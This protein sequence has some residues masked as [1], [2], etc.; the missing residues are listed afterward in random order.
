MVKGMRVIGWTFLLFVAL[1]LS[2][3]LWEEY[4]TEYV[5]LSFLEPIDKWIDSLEV[6]QYFSE[7]K[8]YLKDIKAE[9]ITQP[10]EKQIILSEDGIE[11]EQ[12]KMGM[13]KSEIENAFGDPKRV[14][15]NEYNLVWHTY[16]E[17]YLNFFMVSYNDE[18][19]VNALFTNQPSFQSFLGLEMESTRDEVLNTLGDPIK[20]LRKG[21]IIYLLPDTGEYDLFLIN[22]NY[23]TFFYDL[24]ENQT[25]TAIQII[26]KE[27]EKNQSNTFGE[28]SEELKKGFE[29][30]LFDLTNSA[31]AIRGLP[32]LTYDKTISETARKH[33]NDM[34]AH[35]YFA[36]ENL[37]GESPFDRLEADGHYFS[38][39][40]ENLAYGQSSSIFAH[41][42]LM[43]SLGHRK[44]ILN[45]NY[46]K[47][48]IGTAFN[49]NS[50]PYYTQNF[51]TK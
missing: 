28:P 1:F 13:K 36:H 49:E 14:S 29:Y 11:L 2:R 10:A 35:N 18:N 16:H 47:L 46:E 17:D 4:T 20:K 6:R 34:A 39:A 15:L 31:R 26:A 45:T 5:D 23:I 3:P 48:G 33:S 8:A 44:N 38:F 43:N 51:F 12:I 21:N 7:A 32:I 9:S 42:G 22:D 30:Q 50:T 25:L 24:H 40:G 19:K 41:E 37:R 27:V